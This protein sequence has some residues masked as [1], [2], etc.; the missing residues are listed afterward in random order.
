M[1]KQLLCIVLPTLLA[2]SQG[3]TD[4]ESSQTQTS[5]EQAETSAVEYPI[6]AVA[7]VGM[8][9]D[10]VRNVGGEN[11]QV[12]QMMGSGVDPHLY[13]ATRDDVRSMMQAD[14]IFYNGLMLEGKMTDT[15]VKMAR[16]KPVVAVTE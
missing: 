4:R 1:S 12:Q 2:V 15:L 11:V 9:A 3:C 6:Q 7:T 16:Q 5:R 14:I 8:V 13:K 10:L